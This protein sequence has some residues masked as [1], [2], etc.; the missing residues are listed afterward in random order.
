MHTLQAWNLLVESCSGK[1]REEA[2]EGAYI[3]SGMGPSGQ[4]M[5]DVYNFK[6]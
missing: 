2:V 3:N 5:E 4:I 6:V 1:E